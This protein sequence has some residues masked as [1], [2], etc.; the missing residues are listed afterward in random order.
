MHIKDLE[1]SSTNV[2]Y[3]RSKWWKNIFVSVFLYELC[4]NLIKYI[5]F[6]KTKFFFNEFSHFWKSF[7]TMDTENEYLTHAQA[8][9]KLTFLSF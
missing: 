3:Y 5:N 8:L 2:I 6:E 4:I 1:R 9:I 7:G